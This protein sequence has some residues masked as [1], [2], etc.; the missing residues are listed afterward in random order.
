MENCPD[1]NII[2]SKQVGKGIIN[3]GLIDLIS[4]QLRLGKDLNWPALWETLEVKFRGDDKEKF[5]D[6]VPPY[7]NLGAILIMAYNKALSE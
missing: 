3:Q 2:A 6:Y 4:E 7:K 5:D 1:A